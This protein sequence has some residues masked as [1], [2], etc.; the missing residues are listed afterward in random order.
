[1]LDRRQALQLIGAAAAS[2]LRRQGVWALSA[3]QDAFL[4]E[5]ERRGCRYFWEQASA[6]TGQVRDR[7]RA[8]GSEERRVA[9]VAATGFGLGALCVADRRG[10]L[11][12]K[13]VRERVRAT[14]DFHLNRAAQ[15][16]G[17]FYH[18]TD[19]ET[20]ARI[21][22]CEVSSI[23]TA[24]FLC[25]ALTCRGYFTRSGVEREIREMAGALYDRVD[26]PW[27]LDGE[28]TYSMG[29]KPESGFLK[30]RWN[31]YCELMMLYLLG[32]GSR[33]HPADAKTWAAFA[34][35][36]VD[37]GGFHYISGRDPLF[38]HQYSHAWFDFRGKHDGYAD[39]F[40]NSVAAT[41]AHRAFCLARGAP[42]SDTY[43]GITASDSEHDGYTGWGGPPAMGPID[44]SV[45]PCAAAGSL[46]FMPQECL[47]VL[48]S[49]RDKYPKA[50]GRY[51]FCDA[52]NATDGWYDPDVLGIDQGVSVLMAENLRSGLVWECL[53]KNTEIVAAMRACGFRK[54]GS[55]A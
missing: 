2:P 15:E 32:I 26:W 25:G 55:M 46:P 1:M 43:W 6:A 36:Y 50:W 34:R 29:W 37:Y 21:W 22:K 48:I 51:G 52:L 27:M 42:Y 5:L 16:H 9:S 44:G 4:D 30:A 3:A 38:T 10:Y 47:R 18:F 13:D 12:G 45:V 28:L 17:F 19:I 40:A 7:A 14:L 8:E 20:G 23:D 39:Y 49:L 53:M 24:I 35:P 31:H 54:D 33:T 11:P 41:R